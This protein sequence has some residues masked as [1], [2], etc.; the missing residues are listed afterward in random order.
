MVMQLRI[1]DSMF[2]SYFVCLYRFIGTEV[3][4]YVAKGAAQI[5]NLSKAEATLHKT[6]LLIHRV[7]CTYSLLLRTHITND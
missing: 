7:D 1:K 4:C 3:Y 6:V 2:V 5:P